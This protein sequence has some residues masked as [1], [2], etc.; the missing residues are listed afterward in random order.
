MKN[1]NVAKWLSLIAGILLIIT[2]FIL[3]INP[4]E[5]TLAL[6]QTISIIF[7]L[8]GIVKVIRFF[9]DEIFKSGMFLIGGILDVILG[10]MMIYNRP[11]STVAFI[12]LIGFWQLFQGVNELVLSIDIKRLGF[13]RWWLGIIAGIIGIIFGFMLI[14]DLMLSTIYISVSLG[15]S[16]FMFG[17]TFIST[18]FSISDRQK[19]KY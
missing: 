14:N 3:F 18:F 15:V 6:V 16:M 7:I 9:T 4:I 5:T 19:G 11:A 17:A 12:W 8:M 10:V 1:L 13:K 2:G